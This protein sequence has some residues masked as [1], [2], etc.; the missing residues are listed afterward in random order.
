MWRA[1][2]IACACATLGIEPPRLLSY[3]DGHLAEANPESLIEQ[4]LAAISETG[5]Q[6]LLSFGS[7]GL[8]G[9]P[10]HIAVGASASEAYRRAKRVAALYTMAVPNSLADVLGMRH[11]HAVPDEEIALAVD[12]TAAWG[13]KQ[14]AIRCHASQWSTSPMLTA[15]AEQQRRFFGFEHFARAAAR[16]SPHDFLPDVLKGYLL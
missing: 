15:P 14:A 10:D 3:A 12:V 9:H 1:G 13:E 11:L 8:S 5:A 6:V 7:D 4:V 16:P 2:E